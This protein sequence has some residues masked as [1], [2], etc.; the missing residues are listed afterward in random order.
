MSPLF[1]GLAGFF[2]LFVFIRLT[3][4]VRLARGFA[5]VVAGAAALVFFN[6]P[7]FHDFHPLILYLSSGILMGL[8]FHV[9]SPVGMGE[10]NTGMKLGVFLGFLIYVVAWPL[11]ALYFVKRIVTG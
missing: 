8:S 9:M 10:L 6:D 3:G 7:L 4:S 1:I 5:V 2:G 11:L